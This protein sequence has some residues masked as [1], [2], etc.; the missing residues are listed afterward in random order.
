MST[1]S[2]SYYSGGNKN[3][4]ASSSRR[5]T[6]L[7]MIRKDVENKRMDQRQRMEEAK[8]LKR[9]GVENQVLK[10]KLEKEGGKK[11]LETKQEKMR[12]Q[13]RDDFIKFMSSGSTHFSSPQ[14]KDQEERRDCGD[15]DC[16][17]CG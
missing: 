15:S 5:L 13:K 2:S 1:S 10:R 7:Q 11:R 8:Q 16:E 3:K 4:Q 17:Y 6:A 9:L 14:Q 12:K